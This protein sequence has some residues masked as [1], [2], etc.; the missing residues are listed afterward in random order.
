M[1]TSHV[2]SAKGLTDR[3]LAAK[4]RKYREAK[5]KLT[6]DAA[7]LQLLAEEI[8]AELETRELDHVQIGTVVIHRR[9]RQIR[10][11]HLDRLR[12]AIGNALFNR[13]TSPKLDTARWN[14]AVNSGLVA[15]HIVEAV[16]TVRASTPWIEIEEAV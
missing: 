10:T 4:A 12:D 13:L 7:K 11:V 2:R 9:V 15:P 14:G 5:A 8:S 6:A 3:T 1:T 16:E